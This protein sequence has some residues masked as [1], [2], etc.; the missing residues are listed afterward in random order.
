MRIRSKITTTAEEEEEVP[1]EGT[2]TSEAPTS[3]DLFGDDS[4]DDEAQADGAFSAGGENVL[5]DVGAPGDD[6]RAG[7]VPTE[8]DLFGSDTDED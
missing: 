6:A 2:G 8:Q 3:A 5:P 1:A 7:A 4:D